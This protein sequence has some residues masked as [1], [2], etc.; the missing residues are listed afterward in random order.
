MPFLQRSYSKEIDGSSFVTYA[1]FL[2]NST[3]NMPEMRPAKFAELVAI[4]DCDVEFERQSQRTWR[5][6][7]AWRDRV[8]SSRLI[9][10]FG[11]LASRL[12]EQAMQS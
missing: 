5:T 1:R 12:H 6:I 2:W 3:A 9:D 4:N 8:Q 11:F 7:D 10:D